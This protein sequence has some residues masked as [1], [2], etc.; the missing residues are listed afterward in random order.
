MDIY[1]YIIFISSLPLPHHPL[2]NRPPRPPPAPPHYFYCSTGV[3]LVVMWG[4]PIDA[5]L[6]A[7]VP[8]GVTLMSWDECVAKGR[9]NV[10]DPDPP[11]ASSLATIMYTS[12]TTGD[13]KG[14]L[15]THDNIVKQIYTLI[16]TAYQAGGIVW[17]N[18]CLISYLPLAHIFGR[19]NEEMMTLTG[20]KIG[21]WR[22]DILGLLDDIK[23][24]KPTLFPGVPRVF[25]RIYS[26]V[27][28]GLHGLKK[29]IY[30]WMFSRKKASLLNGAHPHS[31]SWLADAVV[32]K[33][34][35]AAL[36]GKV[37]VV[38]AGGAPIAAHTEEFCRVTMGAQFIQGYGLTET[39]AGSFITS[40][41]WPG[42]FQ[43][44]GFV[45]PSMQFCLESLPDMNYDATHPTEPKGE[46]LI[47]GPCVFSGYYKDQAKTSEAFTKDGW[48]RT[49]DVGT[50]L[51]NGALKIIDRAKNM[52]KLAQGEYVS[53]E[54]LEAIIKKN[55]LIDQV[56]LHG[57][58]RST[59]VC[60]LVV[61]AGATAAAWAKT[62][63]KSTTDLSALCRD[64]EFQQHLL[65][66]VQATMKE[67]KCKGF[68]IVKKVALT[69]EAFT[70]ENELLTPSM[71]L[72][73]PQIKRKY[74]K[75]LDAMYA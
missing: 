69:A 59:Y 37:R 45:V 41:Y 60:A 71:K 73:R 6:Q 44:V 24:L 16:H 46:V 27:Q 15:L 40:D 19:V 18:D 62:A 67:A 74:Q 58:S 4:G 26:K 70:P 31:A 20:N 51:P 43:S 1:I 17:K 14:V 30:D 33:K 32:F 54:N 36:G 9:A 5:A 57:D 53:S 61:P 11:K 48:F 34:V 65:S 13:P 29:T 7:K 63:G 25:D 42:F 39:C 75:E 35:K 66:S 21:Y 12:G 72:K 8:N 3:T 2:T 22:G 55:G 47:K 10:V 28:G 56:F 50:I 68:E 64:A 38:V 23:A 52:F 49:G